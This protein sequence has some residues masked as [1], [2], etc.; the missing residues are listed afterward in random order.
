MLPNP[1]PTHY[2]QHPANADKRK[3]SDARE[4]SAA[5]PPQPSP[6]PPAMRAE[7]SE[8]H[9]TPPIFALGRERAVRDKGHCNTPIFSLGRERAARQRPEPDASQA[10]RAEQSERPWPLPPPPSP[11]VASAQ[12][13]PTRQRPDP[14]A[15][16][17]KQAKQRKQRMTLLGVL[18]FVHMNTHTK[19]QVVLKKVSVSGE[20]KK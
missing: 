6:A 17:A 7:R 10:K 20:K 19:G 8:L 1:S 13:E 18:C 2:P 15:S 4:A 11:C 5:A 3:L 9:C 14:D 12:R 16:R